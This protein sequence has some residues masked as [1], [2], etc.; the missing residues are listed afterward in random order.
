MT[1]APED[2]PDRVLRIPP[3]RLD[4]WLAGFAR[5]HGTVETRAAPDAVTV[6]AADGAHARCTVPFPPM[7]PDE[8]EYGG[9]VEHAQRDRRVGVLLVR[10][11]GYASGVFDGT[12]L[13]TSKVG[14]R[15]VQGRTAAGGQSQQR[16]ARRREK[17]AREAFEAAADV[18]ARVLVPHLASL[19]AVVTGGDRAAVDTVLADRRLGGL[20]A[21]AVPPH[22]DVPDPKL[23][24]LKE[25]PAQFRAVRIALTEPR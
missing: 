9:L 24:V 11:G 20:R 22:L 15:H 12:R 1:S 14:S 17:Q 5:R 16:F 8:S 23:A 3:E 7:T 13:V 4:R 6:V 18:A 25:T 2:R 10:R 21:L 19:E